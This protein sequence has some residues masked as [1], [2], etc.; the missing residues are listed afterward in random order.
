MKPQLGTSQIINV[1]VE[2]E[3]PLGLNTF[4]PGQ[5]FSSPGM[6]VLA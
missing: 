2:M 3:S 1:D 6:I 4:I 5:N